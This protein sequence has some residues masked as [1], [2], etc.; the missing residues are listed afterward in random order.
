MALSMQS[1]QKVC[2]QE[3]VVTGSTRADWHIAHTWV[4]FSCRLLLLRGLP[5]TLELNNVPGLDRALLCI[6]IRSL[7]RACRSP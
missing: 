5:T 3:V 2:L 6:H 4:M 1:L 7:L